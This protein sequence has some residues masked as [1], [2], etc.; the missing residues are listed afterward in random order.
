MVLAGENVA[1]PRLSALIQCPPANKVPVK[2]AFNVIMSILKI[3]C[4]S[5]KVLVKRPPIGGSDRARP[6]EKSLRKSR[7][8]NRVSLHPCLIKIFLWVAVT[9][10]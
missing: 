4:A 9:V 1:P 10:F 6:R 8:F 7:S 5:S 2:Q 3:H